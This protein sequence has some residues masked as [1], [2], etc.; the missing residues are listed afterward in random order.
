MRHIALVFLR[1]RCLR[2]KNCSPLPSSTS[3]SRST[4]WLPW[5]TRCST[6]PS[7]AATWHR[8]ADI[9]DRML[10]DNECGVILMPGRLADHRAGLKKV[11]VDMI[12]NNMV[13]AIVSHRRQH[14]RPGLLRGPGLQALHRRGR[15]QERPVRRRAARARDRPHLRHADRRGRAARLRRDDAARSSTSSSRGRT[16]RREF[17]REIGA[18]PRQ[19]RRP[20]V[21][22]LDR[23]RG[24][25]A[26]RAD[27]LPGVQR[28]LGR[29]RPGRP[30]STPRRPAR[31]VAGTAARTSTS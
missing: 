21:R 7:A 29:L 1:L 24:L 26:R 16:A 28:L 14:R 31:S 12:R 11:F 5:S 2:K 27:L 18:L 13:D 15:A 8:A 6:W 25:Q 30:S 10:R 3:T 4:T 9:Y 20:E 23:L 22:R 19:E 17:I